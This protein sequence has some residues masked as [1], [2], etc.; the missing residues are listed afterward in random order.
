[1]GGPGS[2]RWGSYSKKTIVEDCLLLTPRPLKKGLA[3]GPGWSG[4]LSWS[5]SGERFAW[6]GYSTE[7]ANGVLGVRLKYTK[8]INE[9]KTPLDYL[10]HVV[11]EP[12]HLGG[13]RWFF[14]C[15]FVTAGNSCRRRCSKLYLSPFGLYF[16]CRECYGLVHRSSQ[17][18]HKF[19]RLYSVLA[20]KVGHGLTAKGVK[21]LLE[22]RLLPRPVRRSDMDP[23]A[24]YAFW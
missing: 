10:V 21:M 12:V 9:E 23:H 3:Y 6:V 18:S 20:A 4:S 16:G 19:D 22:A 13:I 17:E 8:I 11:S 24:G 1:M 14:L 5:R 15:P 2:S 7:L